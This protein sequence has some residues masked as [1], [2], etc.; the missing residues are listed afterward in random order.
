MKLVLGVFSWLFSKP[1]SKTANHWAKR[2]PNTNYCWREAG[3][4]EAKLGKLMP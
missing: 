3:Q 1:I 4:G 2:P